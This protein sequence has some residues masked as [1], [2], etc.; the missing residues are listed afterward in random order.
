MFLVLFTY[1]LQ[2]MVE[3][4]EKQG[5]GAALVEEDVDEGSAQRYCS[6]RIDLGP[7]L[8]TK[9]P[10][11]ATACRRDGAWGGDQGQPTGSGQGR[12][13]GAS[14]GRRLASGDGQGRA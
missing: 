13:L 8:P 14:N 4:L 5:D 12:R 6:E 11:R 2:F 7:L 3:K 9:A 1:N 10:P